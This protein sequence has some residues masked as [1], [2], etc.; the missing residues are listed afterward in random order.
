MAAGAGNPPPAL[1]MLACMQFGN[2]KGG[3]ISSHLA[4]DTCC[5]RSSSR[6]AARSHS[7]DADFQFGERGQ[8]SLALGQDL[9]LPGAIAEEAAGWR[10]LDLDQTAAIAC[11]LPWVRKAAVYAWHC[12][13]D[14][15]HRSLVDRRLA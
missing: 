10:L 11:G 6:Q 13:A 3:Q 14:D 12:E 2:G 7:G 4:D 15:Q 9:M 5:Y 1:V 8:Q